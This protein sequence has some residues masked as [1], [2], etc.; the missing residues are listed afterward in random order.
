MVEVRYA[1][2]A[3]F[4][5][6][7][8]VRSRQVRNDLERLH[9]QRLIIP[10]GALDFGAR[11]TPRLLADVLD[12]VAAGGWL[13]ALLAELPLPE[14][15]RARIPRLEV[16]QELP[17]HFPYQ[18]TSP[19]GDGPEPGRRDRRRRGSRILTRGNEP[20]HRDGG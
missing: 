20:S 15:F 7:L 13:P 9:G 10:S 17:Y 4:Y 5:A 12:R 19:A 8:V 6:D 11:R 3:P 1:D 2:P 16:R 14:G 18:D